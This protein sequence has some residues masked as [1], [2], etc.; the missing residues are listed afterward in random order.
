LEQ[1]GGARLFDAL[2][3]IFDLNDRRSWHRAAGVADA[4]V[5]AGIGGRRFDGVAQEIVE[6][7]RYR[8]GVDVRVA[9]AFD[10]QGDATH[11]RPRPQRLDA[12]L[13]QRADADGASRP[14]LVAGDEQQIADQTI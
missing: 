4:H 1:L 9:V 7:A 6:R 2:A 10:V 14:E 3:V 11:L 5:D 12:R 8:L 13:G